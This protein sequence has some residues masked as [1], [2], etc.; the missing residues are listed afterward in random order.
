MFLLTVYNFS[1]FG[2][3]EYNQSDFGIDPLVMSMMCRGFSCIIG[4]GCLLRPACSLGRTL[5]A[6]ALLH[7]GLQGQIC[8]LL[9]VDT[10]TS[11]FC[12]P[13]PYNE[14][15]IF[16]GCS[17]RSCRSSQN[18]STSASSALLVGAQTWITVI[19][20]VWKQTEIILLFLS[21]HSSTAFQT[22]LL[23]MIATPFLL[24]YSGPQ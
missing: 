24:R 7:S 3:K 19:L 6:F 18:H 20:N 4:K 14:K 11:F 8:L 13:A 9:Q 21:L 23:T 17:R 1:I 22:I 16:L 15:D 5:L 10:L 2:C 12:I